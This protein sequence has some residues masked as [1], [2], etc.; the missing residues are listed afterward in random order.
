MVD[1]VDSKSDM[2]DFWNL[3]EN[4][5]FSFTFALRFFFLRQTEIGTEQNVNLNDRFLQNKFILL[6]I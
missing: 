4:L 1:W 5:K 3:V 2:R 6:D